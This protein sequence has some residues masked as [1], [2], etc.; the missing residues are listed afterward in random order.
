[1]DYTD[2]IARYIEQ[3]IEVMRSLDVTEIN[4]AM[5]ALETAREAGHTVYICGNGGSASTA[6]HFT[7]DFNKGVSEFYEKKYNFVCLSDN[8]SSMMAIANDISYEEIFRTPLVGRLRKG[9]IL[10]AISGSGNSEN[11][12]RAARY[13]KE[14]GNTVIGLTGYSGGKVKELADISLHVPIDNMQIAEDL[15]LMYDHLMMYILAYDKD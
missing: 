14:Q 12:V 10:L 6:S 8:I 9:D 4:R 5:N 7:G 11:V 2:K 3:E 15:H 1:M 13:A